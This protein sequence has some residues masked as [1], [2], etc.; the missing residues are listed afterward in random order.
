[1]VPEKVL[2]LVRKDINEQL[3]VRNDIDVN[4]HERLSNFTLRLKLKK[5]NSTFIGVLH[6]T[7]S[8]G[9]SII[10]ITHPTIK[11]TYKIYD[12]PLN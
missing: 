10:S 6:F 8:V 3:V 1:M 12:Q 2:L 4:E 7:F 5:K 9:Y 11:G